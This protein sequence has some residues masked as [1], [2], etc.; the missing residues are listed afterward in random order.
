MKFDLTNPVFFDADKAREYLES[1]HWP[2]GAE[3]RHCESANVTKV[4]GKSARPGLYMCNACRKQFT[5]TVGTI[6]EDSKIPLNKWLWAFAMINSGK[7]GLS[8]NQL[9]RN[10]G[11]TYKSAWFMAHRIREAMKD[12]GSPLGGPGK[13]VESDEA[14]VG[15]SKAIRLRRAGTNTSE[16]S[17]KAAKPLFEKLESLKEKFETIDKIWNI[18]VKW[19]GAGKGVGA[20][21]LT[22]I[23]H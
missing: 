23:P 17:Q 16:E 15:G 13:V 18:G 3:C 11:I 10:L 8:A 4:G 19:I 9:S 12:D 2:N 5:V 22:F 21:L 20:L 6:F 14:F 7:K 1:L